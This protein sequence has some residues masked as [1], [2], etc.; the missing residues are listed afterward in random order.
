MAGSPQLVRNLL[1]SSRA[2]CKFESSGQD[3]GRWLAQWLLGELV[4][5]LR[6]GLQ[7]RLPKWAGRL[8]QGPSVAILIRPGSQP[9]C[10]LAFFLPFP[11]CD[12]VGA[13]VFADADVLARDG[14]PTPF[15]ASFALHS[16]T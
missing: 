10:V 3:V 11:P 6:R 5:S 8:V 14:A 13:S 7:A 15:A 4:E 16:G 2:Y 1:V 12:L 9:R